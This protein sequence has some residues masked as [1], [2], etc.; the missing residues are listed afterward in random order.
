[1]HAIVA[2]DCCEVSKGLSCGN[3]RYVNKV[4]KRGST[5]DSSI[6]SFDGA[7]IKLSMSGTL[8]TK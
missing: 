1:M 4:T 2:I 5:D 8:D 6:K 7:N 3:K